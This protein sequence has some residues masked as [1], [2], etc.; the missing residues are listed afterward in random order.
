VHK[1]IQGEARLKINQHSSMN[2]K[3]KKK[4]EL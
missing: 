1:T 4:I 3:F 2:C